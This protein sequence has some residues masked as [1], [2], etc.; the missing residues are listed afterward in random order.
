MKLAP[1][2]GRPSR[3][4]AGLLAGIL[5][6]LGGLAAGTQSASASTGCSGFSCHGHDPFV[7]NCGY[8]TPDSAGAYS[9]NTE[10]AVLKNWYG[11]CNA[12][13]SEGYLTS[14][15]LAAHD[16]II[17]TIDTTD[18]RGDYEF[19]CYPGPD[20]TGALVENCSGATYGGSSTAWTDMVDGTNITQSFIYVYHGSTLIT[21]ATVSQ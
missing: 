18:S 6:L 11:H 12:N 19:M 14:A 7:Y 13:W 5:L 2:R 15:G 8:Y 9:G 1:R 21:E 3:R 4:A 16:S 10:L 20:N 17:I